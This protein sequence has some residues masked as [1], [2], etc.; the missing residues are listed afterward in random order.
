MFVKSPFLFVKSPFLLVKFPFSF[1]GPTHGPG[2]P[3]SPSTA[4]AAA[5]AALGALGEATP[6]V[7]R[8]ASLP[9]PAARRV[10]EADTVNPVN[11]RTGSVQSR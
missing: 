8:P 1:G 5:R 3:T 11:P 10:E 2:F 6:V 9:A 4:G 7:G